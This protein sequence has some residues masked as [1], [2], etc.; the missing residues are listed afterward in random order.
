MK[1]ND[2]A[3]VARAL[4]DSYGSRALDF[5]QGPLKPSERE[6]DAAYWKEV[7]REIMAQQATAKKPHP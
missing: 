4:I 5:A 3:R 6:K 1:R 7:R 2:P